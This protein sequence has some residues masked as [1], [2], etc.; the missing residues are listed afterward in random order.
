M[1]NFINLILTVS[2]LI[3]S[4]STKAQ[5]VNR[6]FVVRSL[7]SDETGAFD[8]FLPAQ[9]DTTMNLATN[10]AAIQ[11]TILI[12]VNLRSSV[13]NGALNIRNEFD[14]KNIIICPVEVIFS[15]W[16]LSDNFLRKEGFLKYPIVIE[17]HQITKGYNLRDIYSFRAVRDL[18]IKK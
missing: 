14:N 13:I 6:G 10:L 16:S 3:A 5:K 8:F 9:I 1:I 18:D 15:D 11:D 12:R 4:S 17:G 7:I 2:L